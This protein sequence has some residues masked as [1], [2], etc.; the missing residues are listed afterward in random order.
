MIGAAASPAPLRARVGAAVDS[1]AAQRFIT[2]VILVNAAT[3]GCETSPYLLDRYGTVLHL[4]DHVALG[5]FCVELALRLYAHRLALFKDPWSCFDALI[6]GIAVL[7]TSGGLSVLRALR[8]LRALRLISV[9]PSMRRVVSA[10]LTAIPGIVSITGLLS[11]I[12]YVSAVMAT[13]LFARIDPE[14]FGTLSKSAFT[15][16]QIMT[17][18][19]WSDIARAIMPIQPYA[20]IFFFIYI[21]IS[22]FVVLNLFIAITVS[23][24][25]PEVL[26]DLQDELEQLEQREQASDTLILEELRA[27]RAEVAALRER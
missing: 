1:R 19:G 24:M 2:F 12:L 9:V 21:L 15:L 8:I 16:L 26:G 10:L 3:L 6:V 7:P 17:G 22:T 18:E 25:E 4:L 13:K 14:H 5:V 27:L 23:A 11:L 20:W